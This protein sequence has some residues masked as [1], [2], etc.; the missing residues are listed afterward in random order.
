MGVNE[1]VN[2]ELQD[3]L[4]SRLQ[5]KTFDEKLR[6][7]EFARGLLARAFEQIDD[8]QQWETLN[9]RRIE[10]IEKSGAQTLTEAKRSERKDLQNVADQRLDA[11]DQQLRTRLEELKQAMK[12]LP[13]GAVDLYLRRHTELAYDI[14]VEFN[15]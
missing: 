4:A 11:R 12:N 14:I 10:L 6:V 7:D 2:I 1:V 13:D 15:P 3:P 8:F 9:P 5:K